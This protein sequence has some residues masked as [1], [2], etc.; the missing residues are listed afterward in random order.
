MA[1]RFMKHDKRSSV[2]ENGLINIQW[3]MKTAGDPGLQEH[4]PTPSILITVVFAK[5][6]LRRR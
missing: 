3:G 2:L 4:A 5:S 6:I 1:A